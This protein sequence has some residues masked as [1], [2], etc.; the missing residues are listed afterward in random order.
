MPIV[1]ISARYLRW[2]RRVRVLSSRKVRASANGFA[3]SAMT[4]QSLFY[5]GEAD[6]KHK[7]LAIAEEEGARHAAYALKLLQSQDALTIA[8]TGKDRSRASW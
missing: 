7:A 4:G 6:L 5:L 3:Y 8:S 2:S 1:R